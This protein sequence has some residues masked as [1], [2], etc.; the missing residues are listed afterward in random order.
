M[1]LPLCLGRPPNVYTQN[2]PIEKSDG[3]KALLIHWRKKKIGGN[4]KEETKI[5]TW[6]ERKIRSEVEIQEGFRAIDGNIGQGENHKSEVIYI[7]LYKSCIHFLKSWDQS[8]GIVA[9]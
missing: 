6:K 8:Q 1:Y 4:G 5:E 7:V 3:C 9:G 2:G